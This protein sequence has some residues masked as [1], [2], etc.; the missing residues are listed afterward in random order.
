[1]IEYQIVQAF[2]QKVIAAVAA[3]IVPTLPIQFIDVNFD[4]PE[5]QKWLELVH[6]PN[7]PRDRYW[8]DE[9]INRGIFRM[10]LHWPKNGGGTYEPLQLIASISGAFVKGEKVGGLWQ[11]LNK[12]K[13]MSK[14]TQ[15][16]DLLF[17]VSVEYSVFSLA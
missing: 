13:A 1:M 14:I 16:A 6:I 2:Q 7:N 12:P 11:V 5:D 8:S 17:P 3:S 4:T 10:I 9:E 15:D